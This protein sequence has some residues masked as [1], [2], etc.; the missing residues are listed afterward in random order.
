MPHAVLCVGDNTAGYDD[1]PARTAVPSG[2]SGHG[3]T[4][5]RGDAAE[6]ALVPEQPVKRLGLQ[7]KEA[8]NLERFLDA[9]E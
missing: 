4:R 3:E 5:A 2:L 8:G 6:P 1:I 7:G 9:G